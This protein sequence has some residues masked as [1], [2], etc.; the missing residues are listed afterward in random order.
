MK[1][2]IV[3][4]G[5][6]AGMTMSHEV[7]TASLPP[8]DRQSVENLARRAMRHPAERKRALT[9]DAFEF[10]ITIDGERYVVGD[11]NPVW[12]ALIERVGVQ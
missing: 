9:P 6:F 8:A 1:I 2:R 11:D 7:D 10:E 3:R 5:G 12:R 4:R